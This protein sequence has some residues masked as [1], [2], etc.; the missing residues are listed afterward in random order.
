MFLEA[1][2]DDDHDDLMMIDDDDTQKICM[3]QLA[4]GLQMDI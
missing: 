1:K 3:V 2:R 4:E